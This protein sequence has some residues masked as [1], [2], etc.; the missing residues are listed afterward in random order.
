MNFY[1]KKK[2]FL[3][4]FTL[5]AVAHDVNHKL[6]TVDLRFVFG[7]QHFVSATDLRVAPWLWISPLNFFNL[8]HLTRCYMRVR[9]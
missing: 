1:S 3:D 6:I 2:F 8:S 4:A 7:L 5:Q 9:P